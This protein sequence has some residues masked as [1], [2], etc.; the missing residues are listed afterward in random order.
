MT[1]PFDG[2][3]ADVCVHL[4]ETA[5]EYGDEERLAGMV[6]AH[7]ATLGVQY[8]R[9]GNA[10]VA[11]TG[12]AGAAVALVGH[13]DTVPNWEGGTVHVDGDRIIGRGAADMKGGVAV[14]LRLLGRLRGLPAP[15]VY[16][17][18]DR[19]EGP[20]E[21]NGIHRVLAESTLLA[22]PAFAVVLEPTGTTIHAGAVGTMNADVIVRGK[23]A[24]S[25]RP[26]EGVNAIERSAPLLARFAAREA[27]PVDVEGLRFHDTITITMA[28]AGNARN[29]VPDELRLAVNVRVA[30]G[31]SLDGARAE[32]ERLAAPEGEVTWL[33][34][35]PPSL[36]NVTDPA[37]QSFIAA[38]G[39][40][41]HP[42]Q[43]WTDVA[44]LTAAGIPAVNVGPGES[45]QAHQR[46]EWVSIAALERCEAIL[47]GYLERT[48]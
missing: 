34:T 27:E 28:H 8:E 48:E 21:H 41:V 15:V 32:V 43:A 6:E 17:F 5:S 46:N 29:V 38:T 12:P 10:V 36:P 2:P 40:E 31:R 3:I 7:C 22:R 14:M 16:V 45:S 24:H 30:P 35:S 42:K 37:V 44:T 4:L 20:N 25:A 26:W 11:R 1:S 19:E 18:Y 47:A 13:L 9:I 33:D 39:L 23:L